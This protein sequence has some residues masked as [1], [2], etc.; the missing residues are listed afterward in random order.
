MLFSFL[1]LYLFSIN[2]RVTD[3]VALVPSK[4]MRNKIAGFATHL[5]R[6]IERGDNVRGISLKLQEEERERRMD[7]IP[8]ESAIN[9]NQLTV[10]P[11]TKDMI[12]SLGLIGAVPLTVQDP[13]R[14]EE[15]RENRG[16][17]RRREQRA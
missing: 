5:L 14:Q 4:R 8:A 15:R 6:R 2:R 1:P 9:V 13:K 16:G 17:D 10:D 3:E 7:F 11:D 12:S